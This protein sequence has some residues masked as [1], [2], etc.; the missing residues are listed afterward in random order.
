VPAFS[1]AE[2][3]GDAVYSFEVQPFFAEM[4]VNHETDRDCSSFLNQ[5][6]LLFLLLALTAVSYFS[7]IN[8]FL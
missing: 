2:I 1:L 4:E 8:R 7:F 3:T 6:P 5:H